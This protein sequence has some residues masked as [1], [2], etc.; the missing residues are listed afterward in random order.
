MVDAALD[1]PVVYAAEHVQTEN[2]IQ[3]GQWEQLLALP[4]VNDTAAATLCHEIDQPL[5]D[6]WGPEWAPSQAHMEGF[7]YQSVDG[8]VRA[9]RD[10]TGEI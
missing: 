5:I 10:R 2:A 6:I 4:E 7:D 1:A 9:C 8:V 3:R